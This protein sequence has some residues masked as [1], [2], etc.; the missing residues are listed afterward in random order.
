MFADADGAEIRQLLRE[1]YDL[2]VLSLME[3]GSMDKETAVRMIADSG[4]FAFATEMEAYLLLHEEAYCWAMV[5]LHGRENTQWHQDPTL[6]PIPER[7]NALAEA[8][9]RSLEA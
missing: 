8:Y 7:Y 2:L 5:L 9:Y 4:L 6:W 1:T 3:F